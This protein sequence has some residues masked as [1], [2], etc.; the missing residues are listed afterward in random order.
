MS[1]KKRYTQSFIVT[2]FLYGLLFLGVIISFKP[3][4]KPVVL[5]D[6]KT[7]AL[8]HIALV[9]QEKKVIEEKSIKKEE[10][11]KDE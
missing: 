2:L 10:P 3:L 7:I 5:N 1:S 11:K 6:E 4:V 8:N 9:S